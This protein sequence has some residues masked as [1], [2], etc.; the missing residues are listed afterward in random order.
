MIP[1]NRPDDVPEYED[2][3][4]SIWKQSGEIFAMQNDSKKPEEDSYITAKLVEW[5]LNTYPGAWIVYDKKYIPGMRA[6]YL[7]WDVNKL[8]VKWVKK[9]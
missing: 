1:Y 8:V 6:F 5:L 2:G 3:Y 9:K 4:I 7:E